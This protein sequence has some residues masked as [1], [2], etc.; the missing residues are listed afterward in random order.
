MWLQKIDIR[1]CCSVG[2][3]DGREI[4]GGAEGG[5]D[6][7]DRGDDVCF[8]PCPN[9]L[10]ASAHAVFERASRQTGHSLSSPC[11][12]NN[13]R[14]ACSVCPSLTVDSN[15]GDVGGD[16]P[17]LILHSSSLLDLQSVLISLIAKSLSKLETCRETGILKRDGSQET[18]APFS[19]PSP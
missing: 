5:A 17:I 8:S 15:V 14:R 18:V 2:E 6:C 16:G 12:R 10:G 1:G 19:A 7:N 3:E 4:G 11:S 9:P 13:C